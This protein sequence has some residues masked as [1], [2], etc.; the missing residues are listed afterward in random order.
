MR[1]AAD[2]VLGETRN[3]RRTQGAAVGFHKPA[4]RPCRSLP[5]RYSP[6]GR[7]RAA[8]AY[9]RL[10]E[11][12]RGKRAQHNLSRCSMTT[13]S[14]T[15]G[16]AA[17]RQAQAAMRAAEANLH[18]RMVEAWFDA[19]P[20]PEYSTTTVLRRGFAMAAAGRKR[21]IAIRVMVTAKEQAEI[22]KAAN[23][24]AMPMSVYVRAKAL[25]AARAG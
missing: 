7:E 17:P 16:D 25:E 8:D 10:G 22:R 5:S 4:A 9:P 20:R 21:D 23:K 18:A 12:A 2:R 1:V 6:F 14:L 19:P 3:P 13:P 11:V 15:K 24:A